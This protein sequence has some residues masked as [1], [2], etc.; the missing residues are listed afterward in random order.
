MSSRCILFGI[1]SQDPVSSTFQ[2][3]VLYVAVGES[4]VYPGTMSL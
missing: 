1:T 4:N 2:K 3:A